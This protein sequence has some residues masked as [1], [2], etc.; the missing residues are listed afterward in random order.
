MIIKE[1]LVAQEPLHRE[2]MEAANAKLL[3]SKTNTRRLEGQIMDSNNTI[4]R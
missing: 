4:Q 2:A 1:T 3:D